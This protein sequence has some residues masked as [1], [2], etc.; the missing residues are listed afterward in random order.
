MNFLAHFR[1][2]IRHNGLRRDL[3]HAINSEAEAVAVKLLAHQDASSGQAR[4]GAL[5]AVLSTISESTFNVAFFATGFIIFLAVVCLLT[6][7]YDARVQIS[8]VT[9]FVGMKL[10]RSMEM[11]GEW[12]FKSGK[13]RLDEFGAIEVPP[14]LASL[15]AD[16]RSITIELKQADARV[17][18]L[19][20]DKKTNVSFWSTGTTAEI[21]SSEG[22]ISGEIWLFGTV[23]AT[24]SKAD[25]SRSTAIPHFDFRS[26]IVFSVDRD[27]AHSFFRPRMSFAEPENAFVMRN[28]G[29][30]DLTF[31]RQDPQVVPGL[32]SGKITLT[33]TGKQF[34]LEEAAYLKLS[35]SRGQISALVIGPDA[36]SVKFDGVIRDVTVGPPG[37][38]KSLMPLRLDYYYHQE[39]LSL[40]WAASSLLWGVV[41]WIV[42][43]MWPAS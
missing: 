20:F 7:V 6:P 41:W 14:E 35:G 33:D 8:A 2:Q 27:N 3:K 38:E 25:N 17:K 29:A 32:V 18:S 21:F 26:P 15:G 30:A 12:V 28:I 19:A 16:N 1:R 31:N 42:N 23:E 43:R 5:S 34:D 39:T 13:I 9:R 40:L 37:F 4:L 24:A 36:I 22:N 11:E 10:D